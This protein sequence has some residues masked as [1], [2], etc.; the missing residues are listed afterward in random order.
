[1]LVQLIF[2]YTYTHCYLSLAYYYAGSYYLAVNPA[3][4]GTKTTLTSPQ[5][6]AGSRCLSFS[7]YAFGEV[8]LQVTYEANKQLSRELWRQKGGD[9]SVWQLLELTLPQDK[10]VY[11]VLGCYRIRLFT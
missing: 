10:T 8:T 11:Q 2:T 5:L 1:M 3:K 6:S 4:Y 7:Y 9:A